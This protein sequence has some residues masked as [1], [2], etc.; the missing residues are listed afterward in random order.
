MSR[1][2]KP[3]SGSGSSGGGASGGYGGQSKYQKQ[4][5]GGKAPASTRLQGQ[6]ERVHGGR[7][8]NVDRAQI[9]QD[10]D[11]IDLKFGFERMKNG[12]PDRMGWLLN[13]LVTSMN[14]ESGNEKSALDL[15][16][17]DREGGNFKA[18][19]FYDPYFYVDLSDPRRFLELHAHLPKRLEG[20]KVDIIDL[21]D[22]DLPNHLSGKRHKFLKLSFGTVAEMMDAKNILRPII[23]SNQKR[24]QNDEEVMD[25]E[26]EEGGQGPSSGGGSLKASS[27]PISFISDMR[28]HDVAYDMRVA[29]DLD[30][31]VG[32]WHLVSCIA[33]S[34]ACVVTRQHDLLELCEPKVLAFDIECEKAPLKFPNAEN[35]RIYMISYMLPGQGYLIINR[36]VVSED[37]SDFEYTPL[38]KYPGPFVVMNEPNEEAMLRKFLAHIQEL[39]PHVIVTYNGDFFDW[40]YLDTRCSKY[41]NL[42]LYK[43]LGIRSSSLPGASSGGNMA[44]SEGEYTGRGLVHLDAFCWVKRDSYLPQGNQGL[45]AVTKS[46]LGYDPVEVGGRICIISRLINSCNSIT[47]SL[48]PL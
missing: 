9:R 46:K 36:E 25:D 6:S 48:R 15:Y 35:D 31:R 2:Q 38:P 3:T 14:D 33:G 5:K 45:K 21:E 20:C 18:T 41:A 4:M 8:E 16:F 1:N 11:E 23:Q 26:Q 30:L 40:P 13:Y 24:D 42:S 39:R 44:R 47:P 17:V 27:D 37:V 32:S 43:Q 7:K 22:L 10:G 12:V 29:I 19:V 34:E 28:E